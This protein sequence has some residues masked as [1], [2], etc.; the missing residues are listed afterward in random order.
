MYPLINYTLYYC[1]NTVLPPETCIQLVNVE[2]K[3]NFSYFLSTSQGNLLGHHL[4]GHCTGC[5]KLSEEFLRCPS[6]ACSALVQAECGAQ[7][8][9]K[10]TGLEWPKRQAHPFSSI[11]S[12]TPEEGTGTALPQLRADGRA[13]L[14]R[15][16]ARH[17]GP[18]LH[19][20]L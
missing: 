17:L 2:I 4:E 10:D 3:V 20:C 9:S 11:L 8:K 18:W 13:L 16:A 6:T 1:A 12:K 5:G 14:S 19:R 15:A 7:I